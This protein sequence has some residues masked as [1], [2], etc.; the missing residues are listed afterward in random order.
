MKISQIEM[1]SPVPQ[2]R[3]EVQ[4]KYLKWQFETYSE[5][6][7]LQLEPDFQR[8]HI[9]TEKQQSSFIEYC[10]KGGSYQR[11]I[12]LN[13]PGWGDNFLGE[14]VL[15]DGLQRLTAIIKFIDN[16]LEVFNGVRLLDFDKPR[17]ILSQQSIFV[18][19]N[20]LKTRKDVL[21]WYIDLNTG[22]VVHSEDE[23]ERVKL[24]L[25]QENA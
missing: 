19:I 2:T 5:K 21:K 1:M 6:Y 12:L 8:G 9:W 15:V 13:H 17:E 22:G 25:S 23:I 3:I 20:K 24:L 14:C 10:L 11:D 18:C 7:N 4:W 16:D